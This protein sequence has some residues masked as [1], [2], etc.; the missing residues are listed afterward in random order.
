MQIAS[1]LCRIEDTDT[2]LLGIGIVDDEGSGTIVISSEVDVSSDPQVANNRFDAQI[3]ANTI[4]ENHG[5]LI[6]GQILVVGYGEMA[7]NVIHHWELNRHYRSPGID[8]MRFVL[9]SFKIETQTDRDNAGQLV[10]YTSIR[11]GGK[12]AKVAIPIFERVFS[13]ASCR[14]DNDQRIVIYTGI[15]A[16]DAEDDDE[17]D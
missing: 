8:A 14:V 3:V 4:Y 9:H 15:Y 13:G 5:E 12:K 1:A 7:P 11:A 16:T 10:L 17:V 2:K 6:P